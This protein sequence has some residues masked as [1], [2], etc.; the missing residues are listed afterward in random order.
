MGL[1]NSETQLVNDLGK[2]MWISLP[3]EY[4][5]GPGVTGDFKIPHSRMTKACWGNIGNLFV[6]CMLSVGSIE[7]VCNVSVEGKFC[8][9]KCLQRSPTG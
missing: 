7:L 9:V 4:P 3:S 6:I 1:V 8:V 5:W 2:E